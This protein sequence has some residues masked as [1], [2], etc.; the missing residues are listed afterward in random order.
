MRL[1]RDWCHHVA[2]ICLILCSHLLTLSIIRETI[3][4]ILHFPQ[5][6]L[7][8]YTFSIT[9]AFTQQRSIDFITIYPVK[10]LKS[11]LF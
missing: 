10:V 1:S 9:G 2:F 7:L 6:K 8:S 5:Q 11:P 3:A 4:T